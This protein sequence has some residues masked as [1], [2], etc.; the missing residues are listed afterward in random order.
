VKITEGTKIVL[1]YG[2]CFDYMIELSENL[3]NERIY[4]DYKQLL[5]LLQ[6][7]RLSLA[8]QLAVEVVTCKLNWWPIRSY[9]RGLTLR[10]ILYRKF[11][12]N[13]AT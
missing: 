9:L 7:E 12:N 3:L 4:S 10:K 1:S 13:E 2:S 11:W 8:R 5:V 6:S